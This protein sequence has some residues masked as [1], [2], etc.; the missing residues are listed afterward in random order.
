ML[1]SRSFIIFHFKF[2]S[3]IHVGLISVKDVG[4][5]AKATVSPGWRR[6]AALL[7]TNPPGMSRADS[8]A[9]IPRRRRKPYFC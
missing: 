9:L 7:P 2:R 5:A 3:A 4:A 1:S 8:F 6:N